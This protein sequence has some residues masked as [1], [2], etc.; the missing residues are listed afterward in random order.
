MRTRPERDMQNGGVADSNHLG[1]LRGGSFSP[2]FILG[3]SRSGTTILYRLLSMTN[4]FNC[5]TAYHL[6][7]YDELLANHR[8]N[9]TEDVKR[10]LSERFRRLGMAGSRFDG[11]EISPD[12]PEEYGFALSPGSRQKLTPRSLPRF[13]ELC[14]KV[15]FVSV[16][17]R[18]LLL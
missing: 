9:A 4:R 7:K 2:V 6:L 17:D 8:G 18:P 3:S 13:L 16:A 15:Q 14:R 10:E 11:V 5:V 12:F 1:L